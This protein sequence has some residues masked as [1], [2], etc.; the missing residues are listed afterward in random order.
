[1]VR[2][3]GGA[4]DRFLGAHAERLDAPL[5]DAH[6]A[7]CLAG[8]VGIDG[9]VIHAHRILLWHRRGVRQAH[10]VAVIENLALADRGSLCGG[11]ASRI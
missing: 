2:V 8:F 6:S 5:A 10:R 1:M 9:Q 3:R 7:R 11:F 4:H